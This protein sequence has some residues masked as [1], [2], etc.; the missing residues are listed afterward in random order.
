MSEILIA[1]SMLEDEINLILQQE[2]LRY[3]VLWMERGLHAAPIQLR[4]RLEAAIRECER[5]YDTILLGYCLCGGSLEGMMP[6]KATLAAMNC[7]DCV[8]TL[9]NDEGIDQHSLY[10]TAGWL[11]SEQFIGK[12]YD[13]TLQKRG[14]EKTA[15][16]Y[17][18]I[19]KGY[20]HLRMMDTGAYDLQ[21]WEKTA[22]ETAQKLELS[23][24]VKHASTEILRKLLTHCWDDSILV[25]PP[26]GTIGRNQFLI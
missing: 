11:R 10:F 12:E 16:I 7:Y 19:L 18:K 3:P 6:T 17:R 8:N 23:Y 15:R 22:K 24:D 9:M 14:P 1:C 2:N 26:G 5:E 21:N 20:T 4:S 25:V 13:A